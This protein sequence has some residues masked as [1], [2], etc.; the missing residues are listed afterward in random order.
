MTEGWDVNNP[1]TWVTEL[2]EYIGED[3]LNA[4]AEAEVAAELAVERALENR[5]FDEAEQE[6]DRER[7]L[8]PVIELYPRI[9]W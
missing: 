3:A 6:R 8:A 7:G 1:P 4:E 2:Y 5:G 9:V